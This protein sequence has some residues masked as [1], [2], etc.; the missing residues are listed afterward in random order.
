MH[1]NIAYQTAGTDEISVQKMRFAIINRRP[2][3]SAKDRDKIRAEIERQLFAVF[4]KNV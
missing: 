1:D 2:Q 3:Y 4:Q